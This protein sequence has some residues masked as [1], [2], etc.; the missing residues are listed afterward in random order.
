MPNMAS[1][2]A[3]TNGHKVNKYVKD[4]PIPKRPNDNQL[5]NGSLNNINKACNCILITH[6]L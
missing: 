2:I 5:K 6:A 4:N 1:I 3:S